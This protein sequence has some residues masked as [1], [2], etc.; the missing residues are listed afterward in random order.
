MMCPFL[1]VLV[2]ALTKAKCSDSSTPVL[3][4]CLTRG[5][6]REEL[7]FLG[8]NCSVNCFAV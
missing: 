4:S 7:K 5:F 1:L 8:L 3:T 6:W 2:S